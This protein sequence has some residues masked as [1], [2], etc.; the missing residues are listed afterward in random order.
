MHAG[1]LNK[2]TQFS[3]ESFDILNLEAVEYPLLAIIFV[4]YN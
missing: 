4:C 3:K 2:L 1:Y